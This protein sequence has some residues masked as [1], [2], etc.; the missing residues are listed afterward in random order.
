MLRELIP[1]DCDYLQKKRLQC[2]QHKDAEVLS[3]ALP[4]VRRRGRGPACRLPIHYQTCTPNPRKEA[5][6]PLQY[7]CKYCPHV[8]VYSPP[9]SSDVDRG[10]SCF[11]TQEAEQGYPKSQ[12]P[13]SAPR[14]KRLTLIKHQSSEKDSQI[15]TVNENGKDI[16]L[17]QSLT[18]S[19]FLRPDSSCSRKSELLN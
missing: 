12:W 14:S 18:P 7:S 2:F 16:C 8:H 1:D 6:F 3:S 13:R 10:H 11:S 5:M 4:R 19:C 15:K 9:Y 17:P